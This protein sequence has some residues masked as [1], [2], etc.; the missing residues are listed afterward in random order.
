MEIVCKRCGCGELMRS[1]FASGKQRYQCKSCGMH[2][3]EGDKRRKYSERLI[4]AA[5]ELYL[6][7]NEFRRI[8]RL[9]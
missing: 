4:N 8:S 5:L 2:F 3:T 1:G 7:G 9:L 6:E